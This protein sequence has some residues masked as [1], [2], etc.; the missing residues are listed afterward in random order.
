MARVDQNVL[1]QLAEDVDRGPEDFVV[2]K[3]IVEKVPSIFNGD[4]DGSQIAVALLTCIRNLSELFGKHPE[5]EGRIEHSLV[6]VGT[7]HEDGL[8]D[9]CRNDSN[10]SFRFFLQLL[11]G[12]A[13]FL[14]FAILLFEATLLL[15]LCLDGLVHN[16]A[17]D[18]GSKR[19]T[20]RL[21]TLDEH[22]QKQS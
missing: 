9:G 7:L 3:W 2:S 18:V 8:T 17:F 21:A 5:G 4:Y 19:L 10:R 16:E 14:L 11:V 1:D 20:Y 15:I 22:L 12:F 6:E 13:T